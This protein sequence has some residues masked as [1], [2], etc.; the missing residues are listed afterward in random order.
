M[1]FLHTDVSLSHSFWVLKG[2]LRVCRVECRMEAVVPWTE[3]NHEQLHS[4]Q[5]VSGP[6]FE[7]ETKRIRSMNV[8]LVYDVRSS[9]LLS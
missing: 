3:E 5:L 9:L 7:T 6:R 1:H 4:E 8:N 2:F